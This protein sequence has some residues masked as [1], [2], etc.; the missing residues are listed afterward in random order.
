MADNF[1]ERQ[2]C[3]YEERKMIWL[4]KK[5]HLPHKRPHHIE[6]ENENDL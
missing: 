5:K 3:D 2:R 1:L 4:R 6:K